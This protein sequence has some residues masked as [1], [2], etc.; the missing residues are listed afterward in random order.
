MSKSF[1]VEPVLL[2]P[3]LYPSMEQSVVWLHLYFVCL[4]GY[5]ALQLQP[6]PMQSRVTLM[7]RPDGLIGLSCSLVTCAD[8]EVAPF[9]NYK[10]NY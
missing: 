10:G 8:P 3:L 7:D 2:C 4:A 1:P 9:S 6:S 5:I